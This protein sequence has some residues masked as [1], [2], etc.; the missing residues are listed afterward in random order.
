MPEVTWRDLTEPQQELLGDITDPD[1]DDDGHLWRCDPI[2]ER[3]AKALVRKGVMEPY[4]AYRLTPTGT[5]MVDD[6]RT[7]GLVA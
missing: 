6:A 3:V 1:E 2:T 7:R 4:T 5:A